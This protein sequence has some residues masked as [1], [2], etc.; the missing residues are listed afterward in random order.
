M[1]EYREEEFDF[2]DAER[3]QVK[4]Q[5]A[6]IG[7]SGSGK[8]V[9]A[10]KMAYGL[11]GDWSKIGIAD[12]EHDRSKVYVGTT[13]T[14]GEV[15]GKFKHMRIVPPYTPDKFSTV[16]R[17]AAAAGIETLIFD[18][19]SH[20]WEGQGG[21]TDWANELGGEFRHW[22]QPKMAHKVLI[23]EIMHAPMN[24]IVTIRTKQEYVVV[25]GGGQNGKSSVEKLGMKPVQS[26]DIDYEFL[27]AFTV[28][29]NNAAIATKDNTGL[30]KGMND[31]ITEDH[32]RMLKEWLSEGKEV[33]TVED[34]KIAEEKIRLEYVKKFT[35]M[36]NSSPAFQ[37]FFT[38][39]EIKLGNVALKNWNLKQLESMQKILDEKKAAQEA[40]KAA[41]AAKAKQEQEQQPEEQQPASDE[42]VDRTAALL[43]I[44]T[45]CKHENV[46][47]AKDQYLK[48]VKVGN[49][50]NLKD[51]RLKFLLDLVRVKAK[52]AEKEAVS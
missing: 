26:G 2:V 51:E 29:M 20:E 30:Y 43:E 10:L 35:D 23:D 18:S 22:K 49:I 33:A 37:K 11:T 48:K 25:P 13:H 14:G 8:T 36:R 4:A 45:L 19:F 24:V 9:G 46:N 38:T 6:I 39:Y 42:G 1:S 12:T 32:G 21:I 3:E 16:L 47:E 40:K 50:E 27:V 31:L 7:P 34:Q 44:Q 5:V 52:S 41:A 28:D 17:K 15:I